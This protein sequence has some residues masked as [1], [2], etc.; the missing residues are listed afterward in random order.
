MTYPLR[1]SAEA[2]SVCVDFKPRA[3]M[4]LEELAVSFKL[5][6]GEIFDEIRVENVEWTLAEFID[7]SLKKLEV[8]H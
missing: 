7:E 3:V 1:V 6:S 5:Q 2:S 4:N 8:S